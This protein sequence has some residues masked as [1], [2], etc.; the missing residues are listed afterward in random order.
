MRS[1][2]FIFL[3]SIF[4]HINSFSQIELDGS[5]QADTLALLSDVNAERFNEMIHDNPLTFQEKS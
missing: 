5:M 4:S 3:L 2:I 1:S